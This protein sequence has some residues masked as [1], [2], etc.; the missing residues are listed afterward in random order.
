MES[1]FHV[2]IVEY[3]TTT[4]TKTQRGETVVVRPD[5]ESSRPQ[6]L[7]LLKPLAERLL[8]DLQK[9][10]PRI[11][12]LLLLPLVAG[13]GCSGH[14]EVSTET[15]SPS[16]A[17]ES[18]EKFDTQVSLSLLTDEDEPSLPQQP[19]EP[20]EPPKNENGTVKVKGD[21]NVVVAVEGDVHFHRH[22]HEHL[23]LENRPA[24]KPPAQER[25]NFE[26]VRIEVQRPR[27]DPE[28]E[29]LLD[30]HLERV[31]A[32]KAMMGL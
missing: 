25:K 2:H 10:L 16:E 24:E 5:P 15:R 19:P 6:N 28:C 11:S 12:L 18:V 21:G 22:F 27:P 29:R 17:L 14:V 1:D 3:L 13:G 30:E 7:P 4:P 20:T 8:S 26:P 32:W 31:E 23:H 9:H